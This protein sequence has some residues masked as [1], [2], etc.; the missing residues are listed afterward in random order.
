MDGAKASDKHIG[1]RKGY[2]P[3]GERACKFTFLIDGRHLTVMCAFTTRGFIAWEIYEGSISNIHISDFLRRK[4]APLMTSKSFLL[5][6]NSSLHHHPDAF[7][8][9]C[10][11]SNGKF[12]FSVPYAHD[13]KPVERGINLVKA[14]LRDNDRDHSR[15][16]IGTLN[17]AFSEYSPTGAQ[18]HVAYELWNQYFRNYD[19]FM[20]E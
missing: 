3:V 5:L 12:Q 6:D 2:A 7:H 1:A 15:D 19:S 20:K 16:P 11:L 10:T 13:S 4:V 9:I 14:W 8:T 18:G 17:R